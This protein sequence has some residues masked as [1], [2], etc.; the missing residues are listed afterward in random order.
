MSE[1]PVRERVPLADM[2]SLG[3]GGTARWF[4]LASSAD[5]VA[6]AEAWCTA[7]GIDLAVLGGGTNVVIAD[8]GVVGLVLRLA[9]RGVE[10]VEGPDELCVTA[11]AGEPWDGIVSSTVARGFAGLESLSGIPG[12]VGGTPIQNVGAYGQEVAGAIEHVSAFDRRSRELVSLPAG[13]CGFGYRTSRF[14]AAD[15]GRFVVCGVTFRLRRGAPT[16]AYPDLDAELVRQGC[17]APGVTDVRS[18][19]LAVRRRKGMGIDA[20]DPDTRSVGAFLANPVVAA[21]IVERLAAAAGAAPPAFAQPDGRAK[22]P[23]AL[24]IERAGFA[25]GERDGAVGL[26]SKH[27]LAIINRGGATAADVLRLACRI[28]R[29]VVDRFG[30]WLLP[31]PVFMGFE[32]DSELAYLQRANG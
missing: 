4:A 5:D 28:K 32:H 9:M 30:V 7:R 16:V 27:T 2:T 21:D 8:A 6:A 26:S 20:A 11:A 25:K 22:V 29:R 18:A 13:A 10:V 24:L 19:V 12:L 14:K 15:A 17:R 31:E 23:A 3:V 1:L